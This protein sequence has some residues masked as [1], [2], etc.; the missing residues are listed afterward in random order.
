MNA[1]Y[2]ASPINASNL[3]VVLCRVVSCISRVVLVIAVNNLRLSGAGK[4]PVMSFDKMLLWRRLF[5]PC[6]LPLPPVDRWG[7]L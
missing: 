5:L 1:A 2:D 7:R 4:L 6:S 3:L